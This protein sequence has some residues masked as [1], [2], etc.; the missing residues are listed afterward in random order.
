MTA[1]VD[2][3]E[4]KKW[5]IHVKL[6]SWLRPRG[7]TVP[8]LKIN[9]ISCFLR[10]SWLARSEDKPRNIHVKWCE[11]FAFSVLVRLLFSSMPVL[12][13]VN[14]WLQ[15]AYWHTIESALQTFFAVANGYRG[16]NVSLRRDYV[17]LYLS[18]T[19]LV[20]WLSAVERQRQTLPLFLRNMQRLQ[21]TVSY[22]PI[23]ATFHWGRRAS[24]L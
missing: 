18:R 15:R 6:K 23:S 19:Q 16:Q 8:Y 20:Q 22:C 7:P 24:W 13:P 9:L 3:R 10:Y 11:L 4:R 21:C 14:G 12:Y 2:V 17:A 5:V 1:H